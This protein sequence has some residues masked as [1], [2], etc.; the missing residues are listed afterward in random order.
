MRNLFQVNVEEG[1]HLWAM[2]YLLQKYFGSDGRDEAEALLQ[3]RSGDPDTP[4]MLGAFNEKTPDWLSFFMFT[5]FTDR[6]GKMQLEALAQSGFDPLSRTC[7]FMLTE[8]AHHM[9]VGE[10]GVTRV[11]ER[12]CQAMQEAGI[13]DP[14]DIAAVRKLGVI[15][16]PTI[17]KK[18]N[19]HFSL[20]L[21]LFGNEIST[22]AANA[23]HAGL[24]GR[25]RE[26]RLKDDHQLES[27]TYPVLRLIDGKIQNED[28]PALSALNMRLRDDYVNDCNVGIGR[29]NKVIE[30]FNIPFQ[31]KLPHVA[32]HR[33]IGEFSTVHADLD[34]I[35]MSDAD[36]EKRQGE[37]VPSD[38]DRDFIESLMQPQYEPAKFA[39]W[40][41][42]P[43]VGI[44]NKPGDFEYVKLA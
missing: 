9:F 32:F 8:E 31:I 5:Y 14:H 36:W 1:R 44:D 17:Q 3:R 29:W 20:S 15:D 23:F 40:I 22:N 11:I 33:H 16:L 34:G 7:R 4:R 2:V 6:D 42:P 27:G 12:T 13:E 38:G 35:L 19:L 30:G 24:K 25:Y 43:K 37:F 26:E 18:A 10:T 41:A 21:D 28:V 39:G